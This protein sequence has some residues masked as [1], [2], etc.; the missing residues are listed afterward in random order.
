M[1]LTLPYKTYKLLLVLAFGKTIPGQSHKIKLELSIMV[2]RC[3]VLPG[4]LLALTTLWPMMPLM[5]LD[6]P[7]LGGP[8]T[9]TT[10]RSIVIGSDWG[11][12]RGIEGSS[13]LEEQEEEEEEERFEGAWEGVM[14]VISWI[15]SPFW[16]FFWRFR[17]Y[18]DYQN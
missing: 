17:F 18:R 1:T 14:L 9:P 5:K 4:V 6:L 3:L 12:E 8:T 2:C 15:I 16:V 7:T 13:S 11:R 10:I